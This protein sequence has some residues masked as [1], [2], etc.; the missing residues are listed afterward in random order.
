[1][2]LVDREIF[3]HYG[4][5]IILTITM[6][7]VTLIAL[8]GTMRLLAFKCGRTPASCSGDEKNTEFCLMRKVGGKS[9]RDIQ[10]KRRL[11]SGSMN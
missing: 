8:S 1:M 11:K 4:I 9:K 6:T 5:K 2:K 3:E 10:H 7:S